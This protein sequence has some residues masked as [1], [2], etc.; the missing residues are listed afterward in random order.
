MWSRSY[1]C[2]V[3]CGRTIFKHVGRGVCN[4]CYLAKYR[5][6]PGNAAR[7]AN[8]KHEW[9]V[10]NGGKEL[11]KLKREERNFDGRREEI[12]VR[13]GQACRKCGKSS[14]KAKLVVHHIDG[15]GRGSPN[16]NNDDSNLITLCRACHAA[17][18]SSINQW[19]RKFKHCQNC[20]TTSV[21]HN[22]KGFCR[23]CYAELYCKHKI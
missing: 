18:H 1:K 16:P 10:R 3:E 9:Y 7:L 12:L 17:E 15:N 21:T 22:A 6:N 4:S 23:L 2:C 8:Q 14:K 19:S 13:D 5:S 20:G 11:A